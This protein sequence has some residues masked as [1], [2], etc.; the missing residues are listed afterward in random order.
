MKKSDFD[1]LKE[2]F[3]KL[4]IKIITHSNKPY[5]DYKFIYLNDPANCV[6]SI[7]F[8]FAEGGK[9]KDYMVLDRLS[10]A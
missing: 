6:N 8:T 9:F 1:T 10:L 3:D 4:G 2:S 5:S 7:A